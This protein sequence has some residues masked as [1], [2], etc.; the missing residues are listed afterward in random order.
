M[1]TAEQLLQQGREEG[2]RQGR[3]EGQLALL[4]KQMRLKFGSVSVHAHGRLAEASPEQ[5]DAWSERILSA[6]S[7]AELFEG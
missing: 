5:L 1:T 7:E 3:Q 2:L 6:S 4:E